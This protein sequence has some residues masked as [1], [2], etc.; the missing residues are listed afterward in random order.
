MKVDVASDMGELGRI[1]VAFSPVNPNIIYALIESKKTGLYR[2][3]DSG[4]IMGIKNN[5][6]GSC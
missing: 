4:K 1:A 5:C 6:T 3:T 2:S